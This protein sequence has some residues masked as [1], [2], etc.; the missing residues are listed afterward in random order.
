MCDSAM[1]MKPALQLAATQKGK[2]VPPALLDLTEED[3]MVIEVGWYLLK[4]FRD[5][6][7]ILE[8]RQVNSLVLM[9]CTK[10]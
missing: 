1:R 8:V 3:W 9:F 5:V 4:P 7:M 2:D 6:Q 10:V